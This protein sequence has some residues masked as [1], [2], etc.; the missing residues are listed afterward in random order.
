VDVALPA[1]LA[2]VDGAAKDPVLRVDK[3]EE[4]EE[5]EER[6]DGRGLQAAGGRLGHEAP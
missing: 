2:G 6:Q 3:G 4:R 5:G 1:R